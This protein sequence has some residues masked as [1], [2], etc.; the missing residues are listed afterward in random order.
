MQQRSSS[1]GD[2]TGSGPLDSEKETP[3]S[4][5]SSDLP[6]ETNRS[7]TARAKPIAEVLASKLSATKI[8]SGLHIV[9][10]PIG[11]LSDI[12]LRAV[13]VLRLADAIACED[14]RVTGKL[15]S[16]FGLA[17]ELI[18]YHEHNAE[19]VTQGLIKR[20]KAGKTIALVSDAG[21]PLVSDPGYRLVKAALKNDISI[22]PVPGAS[23]LLA[24]LSIAGL[25]TDRFIF[26]GFLPA[27]SNARRKVLTRIATVDA[28]VIFYES[29][30]RLGNSLRD[31]AEILGNR[32]AVI[33]RELTK[34]FEQISRAPLEEL[35]AQVVSTKTLK[36]EVTIVVSRPQ[37]VE[38]PSNEK[39]D[40]LLTDAL[41]HQSV[42]DAANMVAEA[43][44]LPRRLLYQRAIKLK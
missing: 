44:G 26:E 2:Y 22:I 16:E 42:R 3:L 25:P 17:A 6:N 27:K 10:T 11:N 38:P 8:E 32:D 41:A 29:P 21:T 33:A 40:G 9:A 7:G 36:G 30:K 12:T 34:R 15:K 18:P 43:T 13:A 35:A 23:A 5:P 24:A 14:T 37:G 39:I 4:D 19:R 28:T 1:A 20:L 31:M